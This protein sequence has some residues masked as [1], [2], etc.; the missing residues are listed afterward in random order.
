MADEV[1]YPAKTQVLTRKARVTS[2]NPLKC[3][4]SPARRREAQRTGRT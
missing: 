2:R 4:F 1:P 3:R